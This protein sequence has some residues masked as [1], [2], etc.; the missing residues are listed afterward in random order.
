MS[1]NIGFQNFWIY[2]GCKLLLLR[3]SAV[4][5]T[6]HWKP[7]L[8]EMDGY[9]RVLPGITGYFPAISRY[10]PLL[11]CITGNYRLFPCYFPLLPGITGYYRLLP[12]NISYYYPLLP[13]RT[14]SKHL[15]PVF[16]EIKSACG[17]TTAGTKHWRT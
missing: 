14:C 2:R 3:C 17:M 8:V 10:Y 11:P 1:R 15:G 13:A 7:F 9:Y 12:T 6:I 4:L 16:S 5:G